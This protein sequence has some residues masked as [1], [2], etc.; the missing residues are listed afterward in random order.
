MICEGTICVSFDYYGTKIER[1]FGKG[2][3]FGNYHI[4]KGITSEF[5]FKSCKSGN[6]HETKVL[7][8]S[9]HKLLSCLR[10][11]PDIN[12]TMMLRSQCDLKHIHKLMKNQLKIKLDHVNNTNTSFEEIEQIFQEEIVKKIKPL[13]KTS[14]MLRKKLSID[15]VNQIKSE[16]DIFDNNCKNMSSKLDIYRKKVSSHLDEII[17]KVHLLRA[18]ITLNNFDE[19]DNI[20][21]N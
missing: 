4:F 21:V 19:I 5:N 18:E 20:K 17:N 6:F 2:F 3:Y 7:A 10:K 16:L 1:V 9:K 8:I 11:Y 14:R 13:I 15:S 12:L